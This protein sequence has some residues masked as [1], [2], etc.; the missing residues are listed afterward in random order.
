[1]GRSQ[2]R[3]GRYKGSR[4]AKGSAAVEGSGRTLQ[5]E[6]NQPFCQALGSA[7]AG[8]GLQSLFLDHAGITPQ[9]WPHR[10]GS[11]GRYWIACG[12]R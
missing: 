1:M 3:D 5:A 6:F 10:A 2:L 12:L 11:P 4:G 9:P 7:I 8:S